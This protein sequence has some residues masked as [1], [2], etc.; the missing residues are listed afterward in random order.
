MTCRKTCIWV[1][2]NLVS[3]QNKVDVVSLVFEMI[4][5]HNFLLKYFKRD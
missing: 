5:Q 3:I 2:I 4:D 1:A